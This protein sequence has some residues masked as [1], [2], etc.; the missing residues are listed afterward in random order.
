MYPNPGPPAAWTPN[1]NGQPPQQQPQQPHPQ[2]PQHP[3]QHPHQQQQHQQPLQHQ[4]H[5]PPPPSTSALHSTSSSGRNRLQHIPTP[6]IL[7]SVIPLRYVESHTQAVSRD[8]NLSPVQIPP[9]SQAL[10]QG[11]PP[12]MT[13]LQPSHPDHYRSLPPPPMYGHAPPG[14]YQQPLPYPP[15]PAP[16]Q[17]TAIACRYCR[18]RKVCLSQ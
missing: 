13:T 5:P 7:N 12:N 14:H 1:A 8:T 15:Q 18:R 10:P 2:H 4:Q 11:G 16:R 3:H 6:S 17:R 9:I